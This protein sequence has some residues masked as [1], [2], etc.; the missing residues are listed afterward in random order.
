MNLPVVIHCRDAFE[1]L[2]T[3]ADKEYDGPLVLHCFTGTLEE[4]REVIKRGWMLSLSGIVTFK[5][6]E[7]LKKVAIDV[8]MERLLIETDAPYLAPGKYR[9]KRNEPSYITE[10]LKVIADLKEIDSEILE[11]QTYKNAKE[12]FRI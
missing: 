3:I 5:K 1:D 8:P 7:E 9:G 10:T 6:S 12:F 4:S 11:K 2:F